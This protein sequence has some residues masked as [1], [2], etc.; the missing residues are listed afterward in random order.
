MEDLKAQATSNVARRTAT[1]FGHIKSEETEVL[2]ASCCSASVPP[3]NKEMETLAQER[4]NGTFDSRKL[5]FML[6][7][8]ERVTKLKEE[9][10]VIISRDAILND[11]LERFDFSREE[12]RRR[13]TEKFIRAWEHLKGKDPE[14]FSK[15]I[16]TLE[17]FDRSVGMRW[18]V[19]WG[20]FINTLYAHGTEEQQKK[21]I[22]LAENYKIFGCFAMT[23]LGHSSFLRGLETTA[24]YDR[25]TDQFVLL[26]P[27][28]T[29][30]KVW[31]GVAGQIATHAIYFADLRIN[32][33]SHGIQMF[34]VPLRHPVTG[35]PFAGVNIGD[36]GSKAGRNGLDNGWIQLSNVR[37]PRENM[38]MKWSQVSKEGVFNEPPNAQLAYSSLVTERVH[39]VKG[40]V[41]L[42]DQGLTVAVRYGAIRRQGEGDPQ[43]MDFQGFQYNLMPALAGSFAVH[44]TSIRLTRVFDRMQD[45]LRKGDKENLLRILPDLHGTSCGM[46]AFSTWWGMETLEI[47]RRCLGGHAYSVYSG[48][49][50]LMADYGV[51]TTGGGDNIVM[52]Q[53]N[54]RYL[55]K[56]YR[57]AIGNKKKLGDSVSYF[58]NAQ[59]ALKHS[60][61]RVNTVEDFF[62]LDSLLEAFRY[63]AIWT[64]SNA[65]K[66]LQDAI[67]GGKSVSD[68]WNECMVDL[69]DSSR[70]HCYHYMV[71]SFVQAIKQTSDQDIKSVLTKCCLLFDL[72]FLE[73]RGTRL[74]EIG[75]LN[76]SQM[77]TLRK[78]IKILCK[79]VRRDA[80]TLVDALNVPD[81]VVNAP[82]GR[83]DGNI[84]EAYLKALQGSRGSTQLAP[85]WDSLIKPLT[86]GSN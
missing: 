74:L 73:E 64:T 56:V 21:W 48:I 41:D 85:Y 37:V 47:C 18:F 23:E 29:S 28:V 45:S 68:A 53:Q 13:C 84:Y 27:T 60:Q 54:A 17:N 57:D 46:K 11:G 67:S 49:P 34:I 20:L 75:Y 71:E 15:F 63:L 52:A 5:T 3:Q 7:G 25:E 12:A 50:A 83:K 1:I 36:L 24:T 35:K 70:T 2:D 82:L 44:F 61:S 51:L 10:A 58:S 59:E 9:I 14:Y 77:G 43:I 86:S 8:G 31:I 16:S 30:T 55:M 80:V 38:L 79:E 6:D 62:N 78:A 26:S 76:G 33:V 66:E 4:S 81:L 22:P 39:A 19:H 69:V 65:A 32:G 40:A 72:K 42:A